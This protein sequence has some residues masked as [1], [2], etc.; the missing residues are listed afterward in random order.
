RPAFAP[1]PF[2][3]LAAQVATVEPPRPRSLDRRIPRDLETVGLKAMAKEAA[4]RYA[5][6]GGPAE[7]LR[8]LLEDRPVRGRRGGPLDRAWRWC[9]RNRAATRAAALVLLV[10]LAGIAGTTYGLLRAERA[11]DE[12]ARQRRRAEAAQ[13]KAEQAEADTLRDYQASTDEVLEH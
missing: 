4:R 9:R 2:A 11:R 8:R 13:R 7:D 12:E 5:S 1:A 10:L 6:A 3:A